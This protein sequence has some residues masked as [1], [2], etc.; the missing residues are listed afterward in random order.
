[1]GG[2]KGKAGGFSGGGELNYQVG[3]SL[4][5]ARVVGNL[6]LGA[7]AINLSPFTAIPTIDRKSASEEYS[8]LYGLR[9]VRNGHSLSVSTG[10]SHNS[11]TEWHQD[12]SNESFK[13]SSSYAGVPFEL[14]VKWFKAEKR[15]F[16]IYG[17][18]PVGKKTSFGGSLGFK[19]F[20]NISKHSYAGL[21]ATYGL[22][23][24]KKY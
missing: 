19:L 11:F 22:G 20:G 23:Y 6:K 4:F 2:S 15:R 24:H 5:S 3:R 14:N 21:G 16:R 9:V 12:E 7:K 1:M 17:L 8:A 10:I 13:V 18:I